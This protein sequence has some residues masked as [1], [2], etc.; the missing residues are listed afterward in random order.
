MTRNT[1][2]VMTSLTARSGTLLLLTL[3]TLTTTL[4]ADFETLY[5]QATEQRKQ[6]FYDMALASYNQA[7]QLPGLEPEQLVKALH[8]VGTAA[9][10]LRQRATALQAFEKI[11]KLPGATQEQVAQAHVELIGT[12][13]Y[14][15]QYAWV[16]DAA[17]LQSALAAY[18][19]CQQLPGMDTS[20]KVQVISEIALAQQRAAQ[21]EAA[22]ATARQLLDLRGV[23]RVKQAETHELIGDSYAA[24]KEYTKA[25]AHYE[26]AIAADKYRVLNK[27]G[28]TA[29]LGKNYTRAMEAF[30]DLM[31]MID[32]EEQKAD[33]N[34]VKRLLV[35]MTEA[36]RKMMKTPTATDA[37][38]SDSDN[39]LMNLTLDDD[40]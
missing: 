4:A 28:N 16:P 22:I 7:A 21:H 38:R 10:V 39:E 26:H 30:S 36:T 35:S 1:R 8:G 40:I 20:L 3:G 6:D 33:Y 18:E 31:P 17:S 37:F 27:I 19:R 15:M 12:I 24:L 2:S 11:T 29:R 13:L 32:K 34:R 9:R 14:P 23:A 5:R 25:V